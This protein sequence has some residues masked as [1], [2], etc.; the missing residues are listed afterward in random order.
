VRTRSLTWPGVN[1]VEPEP[2][3]CLE[4]ARELERAAHA[5]Q[6]DFIRLAREA[7]RNWYE[8]GDALDLHWAAVVNRES[9]VDE[10]YAYALDLGQRPGGDRRPFTWTCPACQQQISDHGPY[11][12]LP[13]Q[14]EGHAPDCPRWAT[15]VADWQERRSRDRKGIS[16]A[17][18]NRLNGG[19]G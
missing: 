11:G 8:I 15:Q 10:A 17:D 13:E 7:G 1:E 9:I 5:V 14:Q 3:A 19:S 12:D 6:L 18:A 4:A 16:V 2:I